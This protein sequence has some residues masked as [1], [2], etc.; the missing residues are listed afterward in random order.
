MKKNLFKNLCLV[1]LL[2]CCAL[3]V[4]GCK[5]KETY[6]YP[7]QVPTITDPNGTFI[8]IGDYTV[9]KNQVFYRALSTYGTSILNEML[10][11]AILPAFTEE[12]YDDYKEEII[13]GSA[14]DTEEARKEAEEDFYDGLLSE[15]LY[16]KEEQEE[17]I[18]LDYRRYLYCKEQLV[19][20]VKNFEPVKDK[21]GNV[22]K[23][24]YF[25]DSEYENAKNTVTKT[26]IKAI[27]L[28]FRSDAEAR[29]A[30]EKHNVYATSFD[31]KGW[32]KLEVVNGV[33]KAGALMNAQEVAKVF[34]E[35][36]DEVYD[37]VD[38]ANQTPN[39]TLNDKTFD[40]TSTKEGKAVYDFNFT[41]G[42]LSK[43]SSIIANKLF[44]DLEALSTEKAEKAYT[45]APLQY[46][47]STYLAL[48]VNENKVDATEE[49]INE[50]LYRTALTSSKINYY[51]YKARE[52]S[53]LKIYDEGLESLFATSIK[54]AYAN[55]TVE[56]N[57]FNRTTDESNKNMYSFTLNGKEVVVTADDFYNKLEKR[58]GIRT[59]V[60]YMNQYLVIANTSFKDV[61][62]LAN[63]TILDNDKY[64]KYYDKEVGAYKAELE[65]GS[66]AGDGY[67]KNYGFANFLR[68]AFGVTRELDLVVTGSLYDDALTE[69]AKSRYTYDNEASKSINS[70][71]YEYM[72]AMGNLA[73][74]D[75][76]DKDYASLLSEYETKKANYEATL[77]ANKKDAEMTLQQQMQNVYDEY[78]NVTGFSLTFYVDADGNNVYDDFEDMSETNKVEVIA[79]G[80]ALVNWILSKINDKNVRGLTPYARVSELCR[81]YRAASLDDSTVIYESYTLADIKAKGIKL[82]LNT[83]T[84]YT[85]SSELS[86]SLKS[87]LK[88]SWENIMIG[89]VYN[90]EGVIEKQKSQFT[91]TSTSSKTLTNAYTTLDFFETESSVGK[92]V[93]TSA[94][95]TAY[96][97]HRSVALPKEEVVKE[98]LEAQK[99]ENK[100]ISSLKQRI[101]DAYYTPAVKVLED[102]ETLGYVLTDLRADMIKNGTLTFGDE[103]YKTYYQLFMDLVDKL[104]TKND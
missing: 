7:S 91:T 63:G 75:S 50:Q 59:A 48:K 89:N 51:L 38:D 103:S 57:G 17:Y 43:I 16:T 70:A 54:S 84:T 88:S 12:G 14:L 37:Y 61:V 39:V 42:N 68:D 11:D 6:K 78:F 25:T 97:T 83:S 45:I 8:K 47:S 29:Y 98:Y 65:A 53:G 26:T 74:K 1:V 28:N 66:L 72:V 5:E 69:Y 2:A 41:Y 60:N 34:A 13:Y 20:E 55:A 85:S 62:N 64:Q 46:G 101:I 24:K 82:S 22:T 90:D 102:E 67:A 81:M 87:L 94:A 36:Y 76:T 3:G 32:H 95:D 4:T 99:D 79:H 93:I 18:K 71:A 77:E 58:Y 52:K 33:K 96:Y 40:L 30:L 19:N 15:G 49:E 27:I 100:S 44:N 92:V 80:K 73:K 35:L 10:D 21:D 104:K 9:T 86:D 56:Y 31:Y 23:E